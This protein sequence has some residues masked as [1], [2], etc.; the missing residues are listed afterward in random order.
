MTFNYEEDEQIEWVYT[1]NK[2]Q[3]VGGTFFPTPSICSGH[4]SMICLPES[5]D[6]STGE[7]RASW[8]TGR[9]EGVWCVLIFGGQ[10]TI[11][12]PVSRQRHHHHHLWEAAVTVDEEELSPCVTTHDLHVFIHTS[13]SKYLRIWFIGIRR[14]NAR[15]REVAGAAVEEVLAQRRQLVSVYKKSSGVEEEGAPSRRL[16]GRASQRRLTGD[17]FVGSNNKRP[18]EWE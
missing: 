15:R 2:D 6:Q 9:E 17:V 7:R 18:R 10:S 1:K 16:G 12:Q 13:I 4:W 14:I 5:V 8:M 11:S 3:E